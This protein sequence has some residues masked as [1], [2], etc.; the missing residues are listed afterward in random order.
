MFYK[1]TF[2]PS[3]EEYEIE[4]PSIEEAISTASD[5]T[6]GIHWEDVHV[7]ERQAKNELFS[8]A[9]IYKRSELLDILEH[10]PESEQQIKNPEKPQTQDVLLEKIEENTRRI[11]EVNEKFLFCF[12]TLPIILFAIHMTAESCK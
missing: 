4:A 1:C 5:F 9:G 3:N 12:I 8:P 11:K 2:K 7:E 10:A 6:D